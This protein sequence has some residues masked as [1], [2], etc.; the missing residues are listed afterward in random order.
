MS[1]DL[2]PAHD[3]PG[4]A[5]FVAA[6]DV[7]GGRLGGGIRV[8]VRH[9]HDLSQVLCVRVCLGADPE[10][11]R[12]ALVHVIAGVVAGLTLALNE[13]AARFVRVALL[14]V[15]QDLGQEVLGELCGH[16]GNLFASRRIIP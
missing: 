7:R 13:Q 3:V 5:R 16:G 8:A 2:G 1:V 10:R 15:G 11:I 12:W 9:S 14:S 4:Q 6:G